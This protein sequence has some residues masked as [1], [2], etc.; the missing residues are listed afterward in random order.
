VHLRW[1]RIVIV[2]VTWHTP[3]AKGTAYSCIFVPTNLT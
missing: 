1:H 3:C 2:L